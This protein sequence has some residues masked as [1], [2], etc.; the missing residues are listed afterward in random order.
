MLSNR[1]RRTSNSS[2]ALPEDESHKTN[3][4]QEL[5]HSLLSYIFLEWNFSPFYSIHCNSHTL[6]RDTRSWNRAEIEDDEMYGVVKRREGGKADL[7]SCRCARSRRSGRRGGRAPSGGCHSQ[8]FPRTP[9]SSWTKASQRRTNPPTENPR[10][11]PKRKAGSRGGSVLGLG[12]RRA[13]KDS[14]GNSGILRAGESNTCVVAA[15]TR[16]KR[17][18]LP[19]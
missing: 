8:G 16:E 13:T 18:G 4:M 17:E 10:N 15:R 12:R 1:L 14:M 7:T 3:F 2:T 5:S 6:A 11:K 9:A 19:G